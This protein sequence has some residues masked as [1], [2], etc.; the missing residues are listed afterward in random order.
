MQRPSA[1]QPGLNHRCAAQHGK[2]AAPCAF[3]WVQVLRHRRPS[4]GAAAQEAAPLIPKPGPDEGSDALKPVPVDIESGVPPGAGAEE[5]PT[6]TLVYAAGICCPMEVPLVERLLA[7]LPGVQ[8][9]RAPDTPGPCSARQ[10]M[11]RVPPKPALPWR[12]RACVVRDAFVTTA[13]PTRLAPLQQ[14]SA[15]HGSAL[16]PGLRTP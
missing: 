1:C 14:S 10:A 9:A 15:Q 13:Q 6:V 5:Q 8:Q 4:G 7:Q 11:A 12:T 2:P 16:V 3:T